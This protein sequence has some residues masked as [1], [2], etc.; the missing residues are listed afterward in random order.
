MSRFSP[1][2][3]RLPP[4][5]QIMLA[6]IGSA[7]GLH[8][9]WTPIRANVSAILFDPLDQ[10]VGSERDRYFPVAVAEGPGLAQIHVTKRVSMTSALLPNKPLLA[11]FWDKPCHTEIVSTLEVPTDSLDRVMEANGIAID[12]IKI[13][14][15]GGEF[16]ILSGA[17]K[18]LAGSICLAE[19]EV[20]FLERYLGLRPFDAIIG[21]MR[22]SGFEL[23]DV[24]RIKRYRHTNSFGVINPGL[25][26]GDR[27]GRIA[28]CDALFIKNDERLME[29]I[30]SGDDSLPLKIILVL[31]VYGKAD[32][33]AW[34]F[35][36]TRERIDGSLRKPLEETFKSL[37]GRRL[38]ASGLHRALDYFARKV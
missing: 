33:A 13:D 24:S 32:F 27:A 3:A 16:A 31:L 19:V 1:L 17:R 23:I 35:D 18:S 5:F 34:M 20:S 28:F 8:R 2:A 4:S 21:L 26:M 6:D 36:R 7:G 22:E 9:R 37:R 12:V 15:Q 25:G 10:S 14:V 29:R 11:R 38:G 30:S